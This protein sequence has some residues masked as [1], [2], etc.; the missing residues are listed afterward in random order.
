MDIGL[1]TNFD[2]ELDH[3]NDF[4]LVTG[5]AAF[6]QALRIRLT[7]YFFNQIGRG[8]TKNAPALLEIEAQRVANDMD[9]LE[10]ISSIIIEQSENKANTLEVTIFYSTGNETFFPISE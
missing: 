4:P 10:G 3:R 7:D 5:T 6:E 8:D 1:N 2:V 9:E